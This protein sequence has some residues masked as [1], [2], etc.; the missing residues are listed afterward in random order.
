MLKPHLQF[1]HYSSRGR[2]I[3]QTC[4][5]T[6]ECLHKALGHAVALG[7]FN[8]RSHGF[9]PQLFCEGSR[10]NGGVTRTIVRQPFN[11]SLRRTA[12][13]KPIFHCLHHQISNQASVNAFG[14]CNPAHDLAV[15]AIQGKSHANFLTV[16]TSQFKPV[17]TPAGVTGLNSHFAVVPTRIPRLI[18]MPK[19]QQIVFSHHAVN[20]FVVHHSWAPIDTLKLQNRPHTAITVGGQVFGNSNDVTQQLAVIRP[21]RRLST[22]NPISFSGSQ[23]GH[24]PTRNAKDET[25]LSYWS[26]PGNKGECATHFRLLPYSTASLRISFSSVLRPSAASSCLMRFKASFISEAGTTG[27]LAPTA[28]KEPSVY[29]LRHW[30]NWLAVMPASRATKET[31]LPAWYVSWTKANFS[32]G[33]QR[34]RRWTPGITSTRS[35]LPSEFIV[36]NID[37]FLVLSSGNIS[38]TA[39][40]GASST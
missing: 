24:V 40:Q 35:G 29:A 9:E 22:V 33:V 23:S 7:A 12:R 34:R 13:A 16:V 37:V 20:T 38:S 17:R 10:F 39:I 26:S 5:V 36:V 25:D 14:G 2:P 31:V 6:F 30:N 21:G 15:T 11:G 27:S 3:G 19:Q 4:I 28:T 8:R 32:E 18:A 1:T